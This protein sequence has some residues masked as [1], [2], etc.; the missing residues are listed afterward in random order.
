MSLPRPSGNN[1]V[2]SDVTR[3]APVQELREE[4]KVVTVLFADLVGSTSLGERLEAEEVK[5][6]VGEAVA[7]I[8]A[9]IDQL[10]GHVKDLAGDGVLAFFGAPVSYEDDAERALRAA[11]RIVQE[12][13]SYAEEVGRGWGVEGFDVRVGIATGP[14]VL[15][16]VGGG[17][18]V[19]YGAYGDAV[20]TAARLQSAAR[21]A[22]VLVD[23]VTRGS[24]GGLCEWGEPQELELKGKAEPVRAW[25]A[26]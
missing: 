4:R 3:A 8:V 22:S 17:G 20:N 11:L 7:R 6:V 23:D 24:I 9:D 19:E 26:K 10:G 25:E 21:P 18:H 12:L 2:M 13:G 5:L 1:G 14:V 15:G 16:T